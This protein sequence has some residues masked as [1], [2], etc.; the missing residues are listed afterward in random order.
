MS[1]SASLADYRAAL[2]APGAT[3]PVLTSALGRLPIAMIGLATLLYVQRMTGSFAVAGLVSAGL[4]AG[5]SVGSVL[6]GRVIDKL[7]PSRPLL[8]LAAVFAV[9]VAGLVLATEAH[10]PTPLLIGAAALVGLSGPALPGASRALWADLVPAGP[11]RNAA[12]AYEAISLEVF[13]ILGPAIA[14]L[15]ITAPWPGTGLVVGAAAMVTGTTGFALTPAARRRRPSGSARVELALGALR[16]PALRTVALAALGFGVVVGAVEVGV[17][18]ATTAVGQPALGGVLLALWSV[19]S[20]LAGLLYGI[21]PWPRALHLR[22]PV[23]L[24]GFGLLVAAM[25]TADGLLALALVMLA[26]GCLITPQVTAHSLAVEIASPPE[27]ATEAWGWVITAATM[28]IA[29]GQSVGGLL[30]E[31]GGPPLAFLAGG[32]AGVVIA[33]L[34]W[35]SRTSLAGKARAAAQA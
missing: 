16:E 26:A 24:A 29:A 10:A 6:Q 14:A 32:A 31:A 9:A 25:A 15:L 17:P 7:G 21:R 1:A 19:T 4:L 12:Y 13:F 22:M 2:R 18:A 33:V 20:V 28:G 34:L 30:V 8:M 3:G 27:S 5:V 35:L 11:V 23:L